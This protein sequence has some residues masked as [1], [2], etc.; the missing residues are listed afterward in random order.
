[1]EHPHEPVLL[2]PEVL[3]PLAQWHGLKLGEQ[4]RPRVLAN[5]F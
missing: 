3:T 2:L 1:V 4:R 5:A